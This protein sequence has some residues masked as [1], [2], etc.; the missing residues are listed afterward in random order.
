MIEMDELLD[1]LKNDCTENIVKIRDK[2][3]DEIKSCI[4]R[5]RE[6]NIQQDPFAEGNYVSDSIRNIVFDE[7][8]PLNKKV[9]AGRYVCFITKY[10]Y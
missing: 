4:D 5:G 2:C 8:K 3:W 9:V 1:A 10:Y 7:K 6:R